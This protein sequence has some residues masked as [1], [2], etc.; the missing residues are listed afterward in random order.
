MQCMYRYK[1]SHDLLQTTIHPGY[2]VY[3]IS[4]SRP[5]YQPGAIIP[6]NDFSSKRELYQNA[7]PNADADAMLVALSMRKPEILNV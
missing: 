2:Y 7:Q 5:G 1:T 3:A 6:P 4:K